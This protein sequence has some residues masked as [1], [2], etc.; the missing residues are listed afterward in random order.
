MDPTTGAELARGPCCEGVYHMQPRLSNSD[1]KVAAHGVRTTP[2]HCHL[3]LDTHQDKLA[4]LFYLNFNYQF[5]INPMSS[6]I[7]VSHVA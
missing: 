5:P 7:I 1:S 3:I 6:L 2:C 4:H